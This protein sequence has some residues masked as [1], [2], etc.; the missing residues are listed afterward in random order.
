MSAPTPIEMVLPS[1][2]ASS[3]VVL[4][5]GIPDQLRPQT[6]EGPSDLAIVA[7]SGEEAGRPGWM[8]DALSRAAA[9]VSREGMIYLMLPPAQR[10]AAIPRLAGLGY[11]SH[12]FFF[13]YPSFGRTESL[14]PGDRS[15][16]RR[17]LG[18]GEGPASGRRRVAS[19]LLAMPES[20]RVAASLLPS[21][22]IAALRPEA[23]APFH[24]LARLSG[25]GV[26]RGLVRAKWRAGRG[27]A[28]VTGLDRTGRPV[29]VAKIA[30]GGPGADARA[31]HEAERLEQLGPAARKAGADLP[32]PV[33]A[34]LPGGWPVL[35]L[36][37]IGGC[38]AVG[39][40]ASGDV[41]PDAVIAQLG[42][43]L[44]RWSEATIAPGR[45]DESWAARELLAPATRLAP[46]LQGAEAY[47]GWLRARAAEA[48]G[49]PLPTVA[50]HGDLTMSNVLLGD[51]P[52]GYCRLGSGKRHRRAVAGPALRRR[53]RDRGP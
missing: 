15:T 5:T 2:R 27:G 50:T 13:H 30:L 44:V 9:A 53:G 40:I 45:L 28:V 4:G 8:D 7:P 18:S 22:G 52:P 34:E 17:W 42:E 26:E 48:A 43:W 36:S 29:A 25:A 21:V 47:L 19:L 20:D 51:G 37:P 31:S 49:E 14:I 11:T 41:A 46:D 24:W 38:P 12:G 10:R 39:L 23:P 35:L 6:G 1:G 16:L 32:S 33:R 3:V